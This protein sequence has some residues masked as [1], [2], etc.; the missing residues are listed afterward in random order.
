MVS[1]TH[2]KGQKIARLMSNEV[3]PYKA[4]FI[5]RVWDAQKRGLRAKLAALRGAISK[6][7][8]AQYYDP[9]L[10]TIARNLPFSRW[11]RANSFF[12]RDFRKKLWVRSSA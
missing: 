8:G 4:Q 6:L 10:P 7:N 5:I 11:H 2:K 3:L 12:W 9:S 1:A